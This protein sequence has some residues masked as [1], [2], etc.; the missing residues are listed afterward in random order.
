MLRSNFLALPIKRI[1]TDF[2]PAQRA[3]RIK[4]QYPI[5]Y[6]DAIAT[7]TAVHQGVPLVTGDPDFHYVEHLIT[8]EWI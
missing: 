5:S 8:V 3:A 4:S 6:A 2:D 1:G 7:A